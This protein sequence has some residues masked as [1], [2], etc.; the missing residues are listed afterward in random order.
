MLSGDN[1]ILQKAT[2]AKTQTGI[3]QEK[4]IVALAYNSALAK[5]LVMEIQQ[6]LLAVN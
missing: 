1:S 4:E 6:L 2:D 3:G 5:K